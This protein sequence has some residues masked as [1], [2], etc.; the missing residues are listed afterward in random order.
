MIIVGIDPGSRFTGYGV[1]SLEGNRLHCIDYG[2]IAGALKTESGLFADRLTRIYS[3]LAGLLAKHAP[4]EIALEDVFHAVNA[5]TALKLG[6][7]RGVALLAAAQTGAPLFEYSPL[8]IKKAV[9]GYGRAQKTQVQM[10]VRKL[11]N[12]SKA[13]QPLDAADALAIAL[14]HAFNRSPFQRTRPRWSNPH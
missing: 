8:E 1:I 3:G 13:P 2:C 14:C 7:A 5:R 12:M 4:H 11:L 9:V 10:M 6:Q